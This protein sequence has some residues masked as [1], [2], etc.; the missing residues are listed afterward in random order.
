MNLIKWA[1]VFLG[2]AFVF[3]FLY[4]LIAGKWIMPHYDYLDGYVIPFFAICLGVLSSILCTMTYYIK[5][6]RISRS[7]VLKVFMGKR[8]ISVAVVFCFFVVFVY[9]CPILMLGEP[10]STQRKYVDS[11]ASEL[12]IGIIKNEAPIIEWSDRDYI[13]KFNFVGEDTAILGLGTD[14]SQKPEKYALLNINGVDRIFTKND[15]FSLTEKKGRTVYRGPGVS[16]EIIYESKAC[17]D[18]DGPKKYGDMTIKVGKK[19]V[20][21]KIMGYCAH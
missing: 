15:K 3:S 14:D 1:I 18:C 4:M 2:G 19:T 10:Q 9:Y 21:K 12:R 6:N 7:A 13:C 8:F 11:T 20:V 5:K 17:A 16:I